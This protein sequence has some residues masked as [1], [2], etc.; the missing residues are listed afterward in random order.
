MD[1][2]RVVQVYTRNTVYDVFGKLVA[3]REIGS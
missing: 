3:T 2:T 1:L